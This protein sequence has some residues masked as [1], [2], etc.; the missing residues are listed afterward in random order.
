MRPAF[1]LRG[2]VHRDETAE[3]GTDQCDWSVSG[4]RDGR[5]GLLE[6]S[7]DRERFKR[8]LVEVRA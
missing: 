4:R 2:R 8:R 3:T 1:V 7:R 5:A 6:H